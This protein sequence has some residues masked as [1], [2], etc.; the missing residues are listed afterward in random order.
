MSNNPFEKTH[1]KAGFCGVEP[2]VLIKKNE[3]ETVEGLRTS[4]IVKMGM[5]YLKNYAKNPAYINSS[6]LDTISAT[7]SNYVIPHDYFR[8]FNYIPW[9][10]KEVSDVLI[11]Q[12]DWET[13]ADTD[14]TWRIGDGTA[15]FYNYIYYLIAGF[16]END[17]LRSYQIREGMLD[18]EEALELSYRDNAPR[19][20]SMQWYFDTIGVNMEDALK[21]INKIPKLYSE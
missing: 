10:E 16:T 3:G 7:L 8:L 2:S 11:N 15:P 18:R 5:Y 13:A 20:E 9:E 19:F 12:Y 14:T 6:L 1:F 21:V 17:T 4:S